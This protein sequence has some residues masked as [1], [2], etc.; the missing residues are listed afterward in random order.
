[1]PKRRRRDEQV[2]AAGST[3]V[4]S[5]RRRRHAETIRLLRQENALLRRDLAALRHAL[6][7]TLREL[8]LARARAQ[9]LAAAE[10]RWNGLTAPRAALAGMAFG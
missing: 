8:Q 7:T 9:C 4:A 3:Q 5:K 2:L 10:T 6:E 1:M